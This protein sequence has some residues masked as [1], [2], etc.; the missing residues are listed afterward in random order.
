MNQI[1]EEEILDIVIL[2]MLREKGFYKVNQHALKLLR[3]I[4]INE[5]E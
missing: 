1:W 2:E 5:S 3:D 4:L